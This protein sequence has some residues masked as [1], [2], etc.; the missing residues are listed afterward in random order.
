[1]FGHRS[2]RRVIA[3]EAKQSRAGLARAGRDCFV[4]PLLAMTLGFRYRPRVNSGLPTPNLRGPY[5]LLLPEICRASA[6]SRCCDLSQ[7]GPTPVM[8]PEFSQFCCCLSENMA[9]HGRE[10]SPV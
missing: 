6:L 9:G 8:T 1:N 3:S 10:A 7:P 5:H 2:F 4:A